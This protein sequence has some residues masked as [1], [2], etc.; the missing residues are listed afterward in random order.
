[1][2]DKNNQRKMFVMKHT[3]NSAQSTVTLSNLFIF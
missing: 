3:N 1:M 2:K